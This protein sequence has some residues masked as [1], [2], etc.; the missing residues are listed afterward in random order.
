[1]GQKDASDGPGERL[2]T[3]FEGRDAAFV[4]L[5]RFFRLQDREAGVPKT[6]NMSLRTV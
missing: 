1:M 6:V 4:P 2:D 3:R 5:R